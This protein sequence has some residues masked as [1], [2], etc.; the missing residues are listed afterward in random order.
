VHEYV[1]CELE[2]TTTIIRQHS[3]QAVPHNLARTSKYVKLL[4]SF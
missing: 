4:Y 3:V 1:N 2:E